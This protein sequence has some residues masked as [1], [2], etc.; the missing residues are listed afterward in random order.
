MWHYLNDNCEPSTY[1]PEPEVASSPT[2]SSGTVPSA[3]SSLVPSAETCSSPDSATASSPASRF[4]T[5]SKPSTGDRGE[6][7]LTLSLE[8]S[9]ARTSARRV[10]VRDLPEPVVDFGSRC[11]ESLARSGLRL[12]GRKTV[13]Y[14]GPVASAPS[15][16]DLPAWGMTVDGEWWELATLVRHISESGSGYWPTPTAGD[17]GSRNTPG[18]KAHGGMSLTDAVRGDG[19]TGQIGRAHV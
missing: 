6:A 10:K 15:Y 16:K 9:P 5:M 2:S 7:Q 3:L 13:R 1:S 11:S 14:C 17:S 8:G 18:S 4:G 19:G 12:S